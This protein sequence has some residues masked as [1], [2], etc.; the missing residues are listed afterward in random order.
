MK[1][2]NL[3]LVILLTLISIVTIA[4]TQDRKS[5][6]RWEYKTVQAHPGEPNLL[7]KLGE[8][9]W[10][11]VDVTLETQSGTSSYTNYYLKRPKQ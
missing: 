1:N 9:G 8:E 7:N 5:I 2:G 10:E 11:L 3:W 4:A 6:Q